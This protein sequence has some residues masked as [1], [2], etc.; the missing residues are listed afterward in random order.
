MPRP[1]SQTRRDRAHGQPAGAQGRR[2]RGGHRRS[3]RYA[4]LSSEVFA[5]PQPNRIGLQQT[6]G[7][8]A[9]GG[10]AYDL[11]PL[12]S[13]RSRRYRFHR[14]R[15]LQLFPTCRIR[16]DMTGI[17]TNVSGWWIVLILIL[18]LVQFPIAAFRWRAVL[19]VCD[20][21]ASFLRLQN[22]LWI[23]QFINQAMPTFLVG[24]AVR[25]WYLCRDGNTA[26]NVIRGVLLDRIAG[27]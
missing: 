27:I 16:F 7:A 5:G 26:G 25:A 9:Q 6:Q 10:R 24:D 4:D 1:D 14:T 12:A 17:R 2:R 13:D 23:A 15:M 8:S 21:H 22:L 19:Q 18:L 20:V 3:G 11:A